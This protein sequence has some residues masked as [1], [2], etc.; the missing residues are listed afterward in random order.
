MSLLRSNVCSRLL[1]CWLLLAAPAAAERPQFT[2]AEQQWIIDNPQI[3]LGADYSWA[4]YDFAN[5]EGEHDGIAADILALISEK[6]GL[7]IIVKPAVWAET[8]SNVENGLLHG[9]SCAAETPQ[10][11]SYL[12]FTAPYVSMSLGIIT[13]QQRDDIHSVGDLTGKTVALNEGSYL[14]EWMVKH[15]PDIELL[16]TDS[17]DASLTAVSFSQADAYIG[18]IAVAT[19]IMRERYL[20][21]LKIA[22]PFPGLD[23][24][25]SV[26]IHHDYP[27]LFSIMEKSLAAISARERAAI[28]EKWYA[29][30]SAGTAFE[31]LPAPKKSLQLSDEQQQWIAQSGPLIVGV[32]PYWPPFDYLDRKG[33]HRGIAADYLRLIS[34]RTGLQFE[35]AHLPDWPAVLE[36]ARQGEIDIVAALSRNEERE[37]FLDLSDAFIEFPLAISSTQFGYLS[38]LQ[39]F[40]GKRVGVVADYFPE[41]V[42]RDHFPKIERVQVESIDDGFRLLAAN[43][44]DAY[45]DNIA[46]ISYSTRQ[47]GLTHLSTTVIPEFNADLHVGV[48]KGNEMLLSIINA[49]L[50]SISEEEH[51]AIEQRWLSVTVLETTDYTL[52]IQIMAGLLLVLLA[53]AFWNRRLHKEV[54]RR[55]ASEQQ[56]KESEAQLSKLINAMPIS[57]LVTERKTGQILL[58]NAWSYQE[59]GFNEQQR[60]ELSAREFYD[61]PS[62]REQIINKLDE[63]GE[64]RNELIEIRTLRGELIHTLLT[65]I[66][67]NYRGI[68]A[69]LGFFLNI[70]ERF[71]LEESLKEAKAAAESAN[72]AKSQFLANM[73]HEIR[74]PMN[75]ILGFA[76]L[77]GEQV[78]DARL[79]SFTHTIQSAGNTLMILIN[80]ILDL[81]KIEAGKLELVVTACHLRHLFEDISNMFALQLRQKDLALVLEID[82][83]LPD[84]VLLDPTR[85]RQILFNLLSNAVKFT[86]E[87]KITLRVKVRNHLEHLSKLDLL[88]EVEDT[89]VGIPAHE[90]AHIFESFTQQSGQ[91]FRKYGGTGLGLSITQRL[92]E[93]MNGEITVQSKPGKGACFSIE[94]RE[95]SI[96]SVIAERQLEQALSFDASR[97]KFRPA[98]LLV[99]DD[100]EDNRQLITNLFADTKVKVIEAENGAEA[101]N[102]VKQQAIDLILMDIRMPV[103]D[104][105]EAAERIKQMAPTIPIVALTASVMQSDYEKGRESQFDAYLRKPILKNDLFLTLSK[106]IRHEQTE[107]EPEQT[108]VDLS[109]LPAEHRQQIR[110]R[111]DNEIQTL[112]LRA[113]RS[114]SISD[115]H[116]FADSVAALASAY[117]LPQ[118]DRYATLLLERLAAFDIDGMQRLLKDFAELSKTLLGGLT[119]TE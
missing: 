68:P 61:P 92:V 3:T 57:L 20:S 107:P 64:L 112:W 56:L 52:L 73:S 26:A 31:I 96:A 10:R 67:I 35:V 113:R 54:A 65:V 9:L 27:L 99:V 74:T 66:S 37:Q 15:H 49:A 109:T 18:N 116:L 4:P 13:Q 51:R 89:G 63:N 115:I 83:S 69:Y 1:L 91:D 24:H 81:S 21:N 103:M 97:I 87:G 105:Y 44:I 76:E 5:A 48:V 19:I 59:L 60:S 39:E 12:N 40:S 11:L 106:Y 17:N 7:E 86:D 93:M 119:D 30:S 23:T 108:D 43:R 22:A 111:M 45:F 101:V 84:S 34:D 50:E 71:A 70:N 77:L 88:I 16:L 55:R 90:V 25:A 46:A 36:A 100:I 28:M 72:Q 110:E 78:N 118:L 8:L 80:D 58:A 85:L 29:T 94:L 98:T 82:D 42:L 117:A 114:N 95:V 104:G 33:E 79:K 102:I 2:D 6:S 14:H 38:G 32:D 47:S 62:Q 41:S 75:A 53:S